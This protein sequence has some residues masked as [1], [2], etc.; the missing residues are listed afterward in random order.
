MVSVC[1]LTYNQEAYIGKT[2]DSILEQDWKVPYEI[3]I[4]EDCSTDNTRKVLQTYKEKYS[5][6]IKLI[7]RKKNVGS[8]LNFIETLQACQGQ[9]IAL[10]EG[11]DYWTDKNKITEQLELFEKNTELSSIHTKVEYVDAENNSLGFSNRVPSDQHVMDLHYLA[12]QNTIHTCSF[13]L[14]KE[15]LSPELYNI[16]MMTPVG[17]L[18]LFLISSTYGK[19]GYINKSMAAYRKNIGVSG[20]WSRLKTYENILVVYQALLDSK[21]GKVLKRDILV[22]KRYQYFMMASVS[23][24]DNK[25]I[26]VYK[27]FLLSLW[28]SLFLLDYK[29]DVVHKVS[30]KKNLKMSFYL[31]PGFKGLWSMLKK[32]L[33]E[34]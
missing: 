28:F 4:G 34:K 26:D 31:I 27:Y 19:V 10:C 21:A 11:D 29:Y 24:H 9:Y 25:M 18:P 32:R 14:K 7:F 2:L 13:M 3:V 16:L 5:E 17:D 33:S 23:I 6:V 8:K 20:K 30:L 15:V 12:Q 1:V 22:S